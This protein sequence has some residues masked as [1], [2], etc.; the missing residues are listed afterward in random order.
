MLGHQTLKK[1]NEKSWLPS[2]SQPTSYPQNLQIPM[3]SEAEVE[4]P[5]V[6]K[7]ENVMP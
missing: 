7:I 6:M 5:V 1:M 2:K 4:N 3:G